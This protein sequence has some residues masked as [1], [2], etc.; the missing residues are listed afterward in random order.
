MA[1]NQKGNNEFGVQPP[2]EKNSPANVQQVEE[3]CN[4]FVIDVERSLL[5]L[6]VPLISLIRRVM[7]TVPI[8]LLSLLSSTKL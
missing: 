3:V 5:Q 2:A 7:P 8:D 4:H 1:G 6:L